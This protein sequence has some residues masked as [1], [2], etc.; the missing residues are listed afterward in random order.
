MNRRNFLIGGISAIVVGNI[1]VK[2]TASASNKHQKHFQKKAKKEVKHPNKINVKYHKPI[3]VK[4]S[5]FDRHVLVETL[6]G[7]TRGESDMGKMAVVHLILNRYFTDDSMFK[8][9]KTI[10]S[11]CLK[12]Y[13]FSCWLDKFKMRHIKKDDTYENIVK[14]VD[15]AIH[16]YEKGVDYSNGALYYYSVDIDKPKWAKEMTKVNEIGKHRFYV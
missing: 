14:V 12:K 11:L 13:Q 3:K 2:E 6:W 10:S 1:A 16:L 8:N 4:M 5:K 15:H 7:E 9:Y